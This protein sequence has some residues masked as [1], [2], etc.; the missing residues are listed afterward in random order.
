MFEDYSSWGVIT[1]PLSIAF[2]WILVATAVAL[3]ASAQSSAFETYGNTTSLTVAGEGT[4]SVD[5][6]Q[7]MLSIS[8]T[9]RDDN[10]TEAAAENSKR[11]DNVI[12]ALEQSGLKKED[13]QVGYYGQTQSSGGY[14]ETCKGNYCEKQVLS[15]V[16]ET[17]SMLQ[18]KVDTTDQQK[19]QSIED[20]AKSAGADQVAISGFGLSDAK[21]SREKARQLAFDDAQEEAQSMASMIGFKI[22]KVLQ[23]YTYPDQSVG[24]IWS[25]GS[26][27]L[28]GKV[29]ITEDVV[30]TYEVI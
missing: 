22:G 25:P 3:P 4:V 7:T 27:V 10:F 16:N 30:V 20:S 6:D 14:V 19:I 26:A 28:P 17:V 21:S 12:R 13:M 2:I 29:T 24:E 5:P 15:S 8:V 23:V 11:L 1:N 18:V 9:T